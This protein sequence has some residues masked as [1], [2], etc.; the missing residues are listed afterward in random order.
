MILR[1]AFGVWRLAFG[2][3]RL[4]FGVWRLAFGVL[5]AGRSTSKRRLK[6]SCIMLLFSNE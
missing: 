1:L 5:V 3:W 2:V 4:A 6:L